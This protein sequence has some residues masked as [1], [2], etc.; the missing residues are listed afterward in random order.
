M[1]DDLLSVA[2]MNAA[3]AARCTT[4]QLRGK[5]AAK[6]RRCLLLLAC[7]GT[8]VA[9]TCNAQ[10]QTPGPWADINSQ[11]DETNV[12]VGLSLEGVDVTVLV[13]QVEI[14]VQSITGGNWNNPLD[15]NNVIVY[16]NDVQTVLD[17]ANGEL[18]TTNLNTLST[19]LTFNQFMNQ[20][21]TQGGVDFP[22][23]DPI[24]VLGETVHVNLGTNVIYDVNVVNDIALNQNA[25]LNSLS[26]G[27]GGNLDV[28]DQYSLSVG[29]GPI[30]NSGTISKTLG[31]G[32]FYFGQPVEN[33]GAITVSSGT[34]WLT[35]TTTGLLEA[36][37]GGTMAID[38]AALTGGAMT[39]GGIF[40]IV[41]GGS[42][43][44]SST[45]LSN[46]NVHD[47]TLN[48]PGENNNLT[49][50]GTWNNVTVTPQT[51]S[52]L[53]VASSQT[54]TL[55]G[56]SK[57]NLQGG[58]VSGQLVNGGSSIIDGYGAEDAVLTNNGTVSAD[59]GSGGALYVQGPVTN[60]AL[61][62]AVSGSTLEIDT[63]VANGNGGQIVSIGPVNLINAN[64]TGGAMTGG[65]IFSIVG[66]GSGF[67]S[68]TTLSNVNV[69]DTTLNIPGENNNLTA[70]GTWNNVTVTPQAN[71]S[72]Q[73]AS[74]QT[75][76]LSGN[77]KLN[78]QGGVVSGQLVNGG[79]SII[80][81]YGYENAG[82]TNNGTISADAG[83][84]ILYVEANITNAGIMEATNSATL[85]LT[86]A[87]L[88]NLAAGVLTM[89]TY[90]VNAN[91][92]MNINGSI[93]SNAAT[94]ILNGGNTTF[95]ALS[96]ITANT[97][98]FQLLNGASFAAVGNFSNSG[99]V[100]I[101]G[102]STLQINGALTN[103][104]SG[105]IA[106]D[107]SLLQVTGNFSTNG[108]L[109][110]GLGG[111][112]SGQYDQ[113]NVD[114]RAILGGTLQ[115]SLMNNFAVQKGDTFNILVAQ[116]GV[117]GNFTDSTLTSGPDLFYVNYLPNT[118]TLTTV[119]T[120]DPNSILTLAAGLGGIVLLGRIRRRDCR[121][122][123]QMSAVPYGKFLVRA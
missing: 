7:G 32:T 117:T 95:A 107:P 66:G 30:V 22:V 75:L 71:S 50:C 103:T 89:G 88:S 83:S 96:P 60:N 21:P 3:C 77:S 33:N 99:N 5:S 13:G 15:W 42:G 57:L 87:N 76:T 106:M 116:A 73:T 84:K 54:L 100:L 81:G 39:G 55:S 121:A 119:A 82:L 114:G 104:T 68:S 69:H 97:G 90:Q 86:N 80:D 49:A 70:W 63:T 14:P 2:G 19:N 62:Q 65:G 24:P 122:G 72:L 12:N 113:I 108:T 23:P 11:V 26:I 118:V 79:S 92:T 123:P 64:I 105:T 17:L 98:S 102:G 8:F 40:S 44:S 10:Q 111:A 93:V 112:G 1:Q 85:N 48:I 67:S 20:G 59:A 94:I 115:I 36:D 52:T 47:T 28:N 120:P 46:V 51:S 58:V 4:G 41:G 6:L 16:Y 78:L 61:I 43:F 74:N 91:S 110:I 101:D 45:T 25:V 56:N 35:P 37:P 109:N 27:S 18:F 9:T 53:Q 38:N 29:E 31:T 34:L